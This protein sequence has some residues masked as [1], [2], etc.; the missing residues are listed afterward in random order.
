M[1]RRFINFGQRLTD[2]TGSNSILLYHPG[3]YPDTIINAP[4]NEVSGQVVTL[5]LL[6]LFP[7]AND[8]FADGSDTYYYSEKLIKIILKIGN[9][10]IDLIRFNPW[11]SGRPYYEDLRARFSPNLPFMM[12]QNSQL[13]VQLEDIG[14][15]LLASDESID[16]FGSAQEE[17]DFDGGL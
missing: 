14:Q 6:A 13:F 12:G 17:W 8:T 10:E 16:L 3:I 11:A 15:G 5:N 1:G 7:N 2:A 4:I 9:K